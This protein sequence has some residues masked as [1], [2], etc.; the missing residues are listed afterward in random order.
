M[1]VG[2]DGMDGMVIICLLRA[3]SVPIIDN[4]TKDDLTKRLLTLPHTIICKIKSKIPQIGN[5]FAVT[6]A[7]CLYDESKEEVFLSSLL[8]VDQFK[9]S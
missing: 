4:Q 7:H 8:L 5:R 2:M 9:N 3:P 1:W 6:A